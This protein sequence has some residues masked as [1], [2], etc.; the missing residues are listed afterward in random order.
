M[1]DDERDEQKTI[2]DMQFLKVSPT[3]TLTLTL[4]HTTRRPST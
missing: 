3:L 4:T 2:D 1:L